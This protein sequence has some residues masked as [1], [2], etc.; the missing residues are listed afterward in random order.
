MLG[1]HAEDEVSYNVSNLIDQLKELM[2]AISELA[3]AS[4]KLIEFQQAQ[5]HSDARLA[6]ALIRYSFI[7]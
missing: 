6:N 7:G 5:A 2:Q 4:T 1:R 3:E